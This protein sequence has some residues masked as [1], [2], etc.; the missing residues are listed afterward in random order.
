M[1]MPYEFDQ[2]VDTHSFRC[3][4]TTPF[5]VT[6]LDAFEAALE[7]HHVYVRVAE[8]TPDGTPTSVVKLNRSAYGWSTTENEA[9]ITETII[10]IIQQYL[11]IDTHC[12]LEE[13]VIDSGHLDILNLI[14]VY[15]DRIMCFDQ[16]AIYDYIESL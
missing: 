15:P 4:T 14:V 1:R 6:D 11:A 10:P 16:G 12:V 13:V 7:P 5:Q 2:S 8:E 9:P 3:A